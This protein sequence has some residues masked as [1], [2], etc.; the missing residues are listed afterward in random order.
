[1]KGFHLVLQL[2]VVD[3]KETEPWRVSGRGMVFGLVMETKKVAYGLL[4]GQP[5]GEKVWRSFSLQGW[6]LVVL[7]DGKAEEFAPIKRTSQA[8][9]VKNMMKPGFVRFEHQCDDNLVSIV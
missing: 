6:R 1:V 5:L 4:P 8:R 3:G 7:I 2:A 9:I